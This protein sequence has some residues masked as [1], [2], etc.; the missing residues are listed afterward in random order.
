MTNLQYKDAVLKALE[1][2]DNS[3]NSVDEVRKILSGCDVDFPYGE[4]E[5][6][7]NALSDNTFAQWSE[8]SPD[9]A[10]KFAN[11]GIPTV[12]I[13][14]EKVMVI[15]P[16]GEDT[17]ESGIVRAANSLTADERE[18]YKFFSNTNV[19]AV[20][21]WTSDVPNP[22]VEGFGGISNSVMIWCLCMG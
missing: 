3:T 11:D 5:G 14:K 1:S 15:I 18:N 4:C 2:L 17:A 16:D 8:C 21:G 20:N 9:N 6:V 13:C 22:L 12:G 19:R 10:I 7:F